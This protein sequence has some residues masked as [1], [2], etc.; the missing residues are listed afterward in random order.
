MRD[1]TTKCCPQASKGCKEQINYFAA[2]HLNC[3]FDFV[4]CTNIEAGCHEQIMKSKLSEHVQ[5]CKYQPFRC[6]LYEL[7]D[8]NSNHLVRCS[9]TNLFP[10]PTQLIEHI[11]SVHINDNNYEVNM[12]KNSTAT[13][14]F[15]ID[16]RYYELNYSNVGLYQN[17]AVVE[18]EGRYLLISLIGKGASDNPLRSML[19]CIHELEREQLIHDRNNCLIARSKLIVCSGFIPTYER[20]IIGLYA[21]GVLSNRLY[22]CIATDCLS[23]QWN[24]VDCAIQSQISKTAKWDDQPIANVKVIQFQITIYETD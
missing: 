19:L 20:R 18:Y 7:D 15:K 16:K 21:S 3:P 24:M 14:D 12:I 8:G 11:K 2:D 17:H 23:I 13:I 9:C 5:T 1:E 10:T 6:P 4:P 22:H